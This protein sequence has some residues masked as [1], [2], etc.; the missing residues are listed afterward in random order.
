MLSRMRESL[1]AAF[2]RR[3]VEWAMDK[4]MRLH[5][6]METEENIRRGMSAAD[7]RRAAMLAFGGVE[8]A[9]EF[10]RDERSTRWLED[11]ASDVHLAVRGMRTN[12][13][14]T[15]AVVLLLALGTGANTAIFSLVNQVM[16]NPL[17]F[18]GGDRMYSLRVTANKREVLLPAEQPF[19][20]RWRK[21]SELVEEFLVTSFVSGR[22]GDTTQIPAP[23][24]LLGAALRP[25]A[26]AF[27]GMRPLLGR[28]IIPA[29]TLVAAPPVLILSERVWRTRFAGDPKV[30]D[31][32]VLLDG[33]SHVV[34]GVAPHEFVVP[35]SGTNDLFTAFKPTIGVDVVVRVKPGV[36]KAQIDRELAAMGPPL[37]NDFGVPPD[38]PHVIGAGEDLLADTRRLLTLLFGAVG[39]VLVIACANVANLMLS[40][41]WSRQ[42]E[43]AVRRALGAG[44]AR[45][46]RQVFTESL[47]LAL[48]G[49]AIGLMLSI[50]FI[51]LLV[52]SQPER[53]LLP[54]E[55]RTD[56][57]VFGWTLAIASVTGLLFGI[58]PALFAT[59]D[60]TAEALKS[61]SRLASPSRGARRLRTTLVVIELAIAVVLLAGT[62][63]I[64]RT[65][66]AMQRAD[67]GM[68]PAGLL[69]LDLRLPKGAFNDSTVRRDV[70]KSILARAGAVPGVTGVS[71]SYVVPPEFGEAL[72]PIEVDGRPRVG[73]DSLIGTSFNAGFPEMFGVAG[74]HLLEGRAFAADPS[75]SEPWNGN[76]VVVNAEFARRFWPNGGAVGARI[77]QTGRWMTVVGVVA[78]VRVPGAPSRRSDWQFYQQLPAGTARAALLVRGSIPT[79][80]L[81][82]Q[83]RQVVREVNSKVRVRNLID[84][85]ARLAKGRAMHRFILAL[86]G[87]FAALALVLAA[88]G[89]HAVISYMVSQRRREI[90]IRVAL[91]AG[92]ARIAR[93][94]LGQG[95][96]MAVGGVIVGV[97]AAAVAT[98]SMR[99]LLYGIEP[100][101]PAT[102]VVVAG[103]LLLVSIVASTIPAR[104]ATKVDPVEM[105]RA[106]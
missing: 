48:L 67:L 18:P 98:R 41:A 100:G 76:E 54:T 77:R 14:F 71:Y 97:I 4:E 96:L 11:L 61:S 44:R 89:L 3:G 45:L 73:A 35:F 9:K 104:R 42:R 60:R 79:P 47:V 10:T 57:I 82:P 68:N 58:A 86:L 13:A 36:T 90:G 93:L 55:V 29:D 87:L 27:V 74:I 39:F 16:L 37:L 6:E 62:G 25:G 40:R 80:Q 21:Q 22:I 31:S 8:K 34:I 32:R 26:M 30:I 101:D 2:D 51:K 105:L 53:A 23:K 7:A 75:L 102:S 43:F 59:G 103:V 84:V 95:I 88:I 49:G 65:L 99:S 66:A 19:V 52:A 33:V 17:P 63:L 50:A 38:P 46:M 20:D 78:D 83:L 92:A 81:E 85:E 70:L 69:A 5:L 1:R 28:D 12:K 106:E 72:S 56:R 15:I 94:V 91:G 64:I 24:E